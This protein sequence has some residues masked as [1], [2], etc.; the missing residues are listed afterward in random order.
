M[1]WAYDSTGYCRAPAPGIP[2][3]KV[4]GVGGCG[5]HAVEHMLSSG[6]HGVTYV[7]ADTD[8]HAL[9]MARAQGTILLGP[10]GR[11]EG[12]SPEI[13]RMLVE[14]SLLAVKCALDES[15]L[16]FIVAGMGGNTG[17]GASPLI[18]AT[19]RKTGALT[20]GIVTMPLSLEGK[21]RN[22]TAEAGLAELRRHVDFLLTIPIE[23]LYQTVSRQTPVRDIF[24][25]ADEYV[26]TAVRCVSDALTR[27][28][29]V[30]IDFADVVRLLK[31]ARLAG[32]GSGSASGEKRAGDAAGQA[33]A[34]PLSAGSAIADAHDALVTV[35]AGPDLS[36]EE[37]DTVTRTFMNAV[38]KNATVLLSTVLDE[39]LADELRIAFIATSA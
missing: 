21:R 18:A 38:H 22:E 9:T 17:T 15:N 35:T 20:V 30:S 11:L 32:M 31:G 12:N 27:R 39:S 1:I 10:N 28:C 36:H 4:I 25:K 24:L 19:A 37:I 29:Y 3:I 7:V 6:L 23:R 34:H 2:A 33:L 16:V 14:E 13:G 26:H 5:F 8:A